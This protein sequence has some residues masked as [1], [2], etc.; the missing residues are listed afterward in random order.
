M[1]DLETLTEMVI[2]LKVVE[3][4]DFIEEIPREIMEK[5]KG[6]DLETLVRKITQ[7]VL[8]Y[9]KGNI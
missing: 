2:D 3:S 8:T 9:L 6:E 1:L 4:A 5:Y 7:E